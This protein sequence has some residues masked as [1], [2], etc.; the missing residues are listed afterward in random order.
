MK[1]Q[2]N[3]KGVYLTPLYHLDISQ[4]ITAES[5]AAGLKPGTFRFRLQIAIL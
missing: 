5:L 1:Q 4:A 3:E 2:P